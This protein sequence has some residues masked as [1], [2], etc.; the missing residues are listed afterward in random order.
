VEGHH[1]IHPIDG[2]LSGNP[3]LIPQLD[4]ACAML[5]A[6]SVHCRTS[7]FTRSS[8]APFVGLTSALQR[9]SS[10]YAVLHGPAGHPSRDLF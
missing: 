8:H 7:A 1:N 9:A 5:T 3:D 4:Q 6:K 10:V 2:Q